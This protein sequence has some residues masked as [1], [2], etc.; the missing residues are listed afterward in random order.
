MTQIKLENLTIQ[1]DESPVINNLNTQFKGG[2]FNILLGKSGAG[3]STILKAILGIAKVHSGKILFDGEIMNTVPSGKRNIGYVPQD[4]ILFP[5][6]SVWDNI[7]FGL[8]IKKT[9]KE[10]IRT[11]VMNVAKL[12][13]AEDLLDRDPENLSG[14]EKQR[15]ALAR[16]LIINPS[17]LL[18]DEP[19]SS[20]DTGERMRLALSLKKVQKKLQLTVIY[21]THSAIEA[22]LLGDEIF[23]LEHGDILQSGEFQELKKNPTTFSSAELLGLNNI[24]REAEI[25]IELRKVT[26]KFRRDNFVYIPPS[27]IY[28]SDKGHEFEA[29]SQTN[30]FSYIQTHS[31]FLVSRNKNDNHKFFNFK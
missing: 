27:E 19:L 4:Q 14:G 10:Q 15:V 18:L 7:A 5:N 26:E 22:E 16:A 12:L 17:I 1:Y 9:P 8:K 31:I 23:V 24:F 25:P 30:D 11:R 29:I 3:K 28:F 21:V 6:L 20:L 13:N 2:T